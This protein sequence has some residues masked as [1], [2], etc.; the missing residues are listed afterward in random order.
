VNRIQ[1]H[2]GARL[3]PLPLLLPKLTPLLLPLLLLP[4]CSDEPPRATDKGEQQASEQPQLEPPR[5]EGTGALKKGF[6]PPRR[7]AVR[8]RIKAPQNQGLR[9]HPDGEL[10]EWKAAGVPWIR[11]ARP[12]KGATDW[13]GEA[14]L[15]ARLALASYPSGLSLA[16]SVRDDSH[17]PALAEGAFGRSD[18]VELE[19]WPRGERDRTP[20]AKHVMGLHLRLGTRRMLV[21]VHR[22]TDAWRVRAITSMG[23]D[24]PG[25]YRVEARVPLYALTPLPAPAIDRIRYRV[26]IHDAD[27]PDSRSAPTLRLAG[28][29][30]LD[31]PMTA[32]EAVRKRG[33]VRACMAAERGA[34]WG[35]WNGWRCVV[36]YQRRAQRED[37]TKD[38]VV[39][40]LG[41]HRVPDPPVIVWIREKLL[42]VNIPGVRRG[43]AVLLDR[44]KTITS[45]MRLGVVG[46]EDPGNPKTLQS[47]VE[48][49]K[50]PDG[51]WA[52][53]V[54]HAYPEKPGPLGGRCAGGHRVYLSIL[55][56]HQ[57]LTSTPHKPAPDPATPP[58]LE[59]VFRGLLEDCRDSLVRDW[60]LS[61]DRSTIEL[62]SSINPA[63]PVEVHR[64]Q[65]GRYVKVQ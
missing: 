32:P 53:A 56:L 4:G 10:G 40:G 11:N 19:L 45:L 39:V 54:V 64:F 62:R 3:P 34:L 28:E 51:T 14:D 7:W 44:T 36:P 42:F 61:R 52:A 13:S 59:E 38:E 41:Y 17:R 25:G 12:V 48:H 31:P 24:A 22:P 20:L 37:D 2:P 55:A 16:L 23:V 50:L 27:G 46:A 33:S 65:K 29:V 26:T 43:L 6:R 9:A 35:Y 58:W 5:E 60:S 8:P 18:H 30:R 63:E 21:Q 49:F 57:A 47:G 15:S 1:G